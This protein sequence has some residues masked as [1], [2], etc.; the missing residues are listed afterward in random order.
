M[1][2]VSMFSFLFT[3]LF[4]FS[5]FHICVFHSSFRSLSVFFLSF[6]PPNFFPLHVSP[7]FSTSFIHSIFRTYFIFSDVS[8][9]IFSSSPSLSPLPLTLSHV[10][11][12]ACHEITD[13]FSCTTNHPLL[14]SP[15]LPRPSPQLS[16]VTYRRVCDLM[17]RQGRTH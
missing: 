4:L 6:L 17:S 16:L 1:K 10:P 14:P 11:S 15:R 12:G 9:S 7:S 3:V 8:V 5:F 2:T 13:G